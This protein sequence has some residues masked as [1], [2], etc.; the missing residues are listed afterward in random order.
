M[1]QHSL[2]T[3]DLLKHRKMAPSHVCA[4]C[5]AEDSWRHALLDCTL[6]RSVWALSDDELVQHMCLSGE[7]NAKDWLFVMSSSLSPH[8]F[9]TII[10]TLW[11]IWY[12]RRKVIHEGIL[13]TPF[14][15]NAFVQRFLSDIQIIAKPT[16]RVQNPV[17]SK[18]TGWVKP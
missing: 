6:S 13:Q 8:E 18:P 7:E 15:T 16:N 11:A 2:S 17:P 14:A 5:G 1:A 10:V 4:I 3:Y 12:A 9:T